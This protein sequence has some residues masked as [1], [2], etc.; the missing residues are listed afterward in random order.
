MLAIIGEVMTENGHSPAATVMVGS[1]MGATAALKF[2]LLLDVAGI[3]AISP[4]IDLDICAVR[5]NRHDEV[6]FIVPSGDVADPANHPYTRQVRRLVEGRGGRSSPAQASRAVLHR[7]RRGARRAGR[8]AGRVVAGSGGI[9]D[10]ERPARRRPHQRLQH[11]ADDAGGPRPPAPPGPPSTSPGTRRIGRTGS[12]TQPP[13]THRLRRVRAWRGQAGAGSL[14]NSAAGDGRTADKTWRDE[15]HAHRREGQTARGQPAFPADPAAAVRAPE[16]RRTSPARSVSPR[17]GQADQ[18]Q[19]SQLPRAIDFGWWRTRWRPGIARSGRT[20]WVHR[21]Q[22]CRGVYVERMA[23]SKRTPPWGRMRMATGVLVDGDPLPHS[24]RPLGP[25][26]SG[27]RPE[28]PLDVVRPPRRNRARPTQGGRSHGRRCPPGS[29]PQAWGFM[30]PPTGR[31]LAF[32]ASTEAPRRSWGD[33]AMA[34]DPHH[35]VAQLRRGRC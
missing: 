2:G 35:H 31:S 26:R 18:E 22:S 23:G 27:R 34:V 6:G 16:R 19:A 3:L 25:A 7:R 28:C 32:R 5:Q 8:A 9:V 21:P 12:V 13:K 20:A 17:A 10:L 14:T 15:L 4:H 29:Q 30:A 33:H 11:Q 1:S 24:R